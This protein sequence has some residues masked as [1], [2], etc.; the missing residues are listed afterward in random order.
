MCVCVCV[1]VSVCVIHT[2]CTERLVDVH[3]FMCDFAVLCIA[4]VSFRSGK[5]DEI[6]FRDGR[7]IRRLTPLHMKTQQGVAATTAIVQ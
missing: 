6:E 3:S 7:R 5:I 1:C 4:F 2:E